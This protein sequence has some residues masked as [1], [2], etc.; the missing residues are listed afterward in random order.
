[1][2]FPVAFVAHGAPTLALDASKGGELHRWAQTLGRPRAIL[3]I[4]AHWEM[5]V[6]ALG[7]TQ[8]TPLIYDFGG[9]P[10]ELY[11]LQYPCPSA[12]DLADRVDELL[13]A[14]WKPLPRVPRGLDHGAWVPLRHMYPEA[15]IPVLQIALPSRHSYRML[16]AL[17]EA[18]SPL[19]DD[20][21]L[22]LGSG[23][24]VHN[25]QYM[26]FKANAAPQPWAVE[27]ETWME[28][29]LSTWDMDTLVNVR[30]LAP[31]GRLAI[32]SHE[33]FGPM[34]VA[35]GAAGCK[36]VIRYPIRGFEFGSL[37]RTCIEFRAA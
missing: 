18:L 34:L 7:A 25:F 35:A 27:F 17:G 2:P 16:L 20:S 3:V 31:G 5:D 11:R 36:S 29:T 15:D 24:L 22:I 26:D 6:P 4:S 30:T 32:P 8:P 28:K 21:I 12:P 19:R 10:D 14:E 23:V 13:R 1:V 9:F 33:H 37:S